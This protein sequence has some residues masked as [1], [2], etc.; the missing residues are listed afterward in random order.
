MLLL[1]L[2]GAAGGYAYWLHTRPVGRHAEVVYLLIDKQTDGAALRTQIHK[3]IYPTR[4]QLLDLYWR[5]YDVDNKLRTG[6]YAVPVDVTTGELMQIITEGEQALVSVPMSGIRMEAD[7]G[8]TLDKFLML[9][10]TDLAPLLADSAWLAQHG[11]TRPE[12]LGLLFAESYELPWDISLEALRDS[13]VTRHAA[14]WT[15]ERRTQ[16]DSLGISPMQLSTLASIVEEES[17]KLDEYPLIA[18]LYLNRLR[19]GMLLQSDPT[20]KYALGD[21]S[22]RRILKVH[23]TTPSP[24]NTYYA[25]GLPPGP[26]R[27]PR[28]N[29]LEAILQTKPH[30]YL[31]MCA[32]EDFSG[33][34]NFAAS[35]AEH[36][37]NARLYQRELDKR[38]IK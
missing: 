22:L 8:R 5:L 21:F 27:I 20:V 37:R 26:I 34:H 10:S 13:I 28:R 4:P 23:L 14:F 15:A 17:G 16:L 36:L 7:L 9:D 35:Y 11:S 3:K 30:D 6:R 38:G 33:Y 2:F 12:A 29:S 18:G 1:L 19:K 32:K 24:Y 31:Y 25:V